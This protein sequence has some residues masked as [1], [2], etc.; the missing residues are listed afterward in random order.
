MSVVP[1]EGRPLLAV[2]GGSKL[3]LRIRHHDDRFA[4]LVSKALPN[5]RAI[6]KTLN[7][8]PLANELWDY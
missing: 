4:A 2:K 5:W 1:A 8:A 3:H 6:R 7:A